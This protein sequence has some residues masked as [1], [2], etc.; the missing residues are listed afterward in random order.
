MKY[1]LLLIFVA[2]VG[3]GEAQN[4]KV[5]SVKSTNHKQAQGKFIDAGPAG[6]GSGWR[7]ASGKAKVHTVRH[8]NYKKAKD[9]A[10]NGGS[11]KPMKHTSPKKGRDHFHSTDNQGKKKQD[12]VHH[13]Y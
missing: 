13:E 12:G 5:Q 1:L 9:A 11:G 3:C 7:G 4:S 2:L 10:R 6:G 8:S